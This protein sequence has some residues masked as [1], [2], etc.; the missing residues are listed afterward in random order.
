MAVLIITP[1][2]KG[3]NPLGVAQFYDISVKIIN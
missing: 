2:D 3:Y 1:A